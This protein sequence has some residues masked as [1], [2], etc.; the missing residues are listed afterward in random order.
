MGI[1]D[2]IE[3]EKRK[4]SKI[5]QRYGFLKSHKL[6]YLQL[7][8]GVLFLAASLFFNYYAQAY[9]ASHSSNYVSD[10][11]LD[12][13]PAKNVDIVFLEGMLIFIGLV[14]L[15]GLHKPGRIP[16]LLKASALFIFTRAIFITLTHLAPPLHTEVVNSVS[17][18]EKLMSGS[19][20]DLFFSGHT[21]FP[22]LMALIFWDNKLLRYL[23]LA[24]SVFFGSAVLLGHLHYSID[25]FS[26]FFITYGIFNIAIRLFKKDFEFFALHTKI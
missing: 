5:S 14:T 19:G 18:W 22:Y 9:T 8:T 4:M 16:F 7:L 15:L 13:I 21:G 24:T 2:I 23:F 20:D 26:A 10:I 25:V 1:Y 3:N 6:F 17:F 11:I 12:H